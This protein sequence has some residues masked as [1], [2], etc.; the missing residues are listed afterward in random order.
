MI[1]SRIEMLNVRS[2]IKTERIG[3]L[4]NELSEKLL[5]KPSRP[6]EMHIKRS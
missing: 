3:S 2:E 1:P 6:K 4:N 5:D